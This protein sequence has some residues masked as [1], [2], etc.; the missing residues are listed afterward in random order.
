MVESMVVIE[1]VDT[2]VVGGICEVCYYS[3]KTNGLRHMI[4]P[5]LWQLELYEEVIFNPIKYLV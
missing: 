2:G 1:E 3:G 5:K 4:R